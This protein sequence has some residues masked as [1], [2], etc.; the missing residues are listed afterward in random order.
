MNLLASKLVCFLF[1]VFCLVTQTANIFLA[2]ILMYEVNEQA[3]F[4]YIRLLKNPLFWIILILQLADFS[5]CIAL[6]HIANKDDKIVEKAYANGKK[7]LIGVAVDYAKNG[8]FYRA[9]KSIE[10]LDKLEDQ[11]KK[12]MIIWPKKQ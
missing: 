2:D 9:E 4:D 6:N 3:S 8:D 5:A 1:Q 10:I 11:Q 12:E 7:D